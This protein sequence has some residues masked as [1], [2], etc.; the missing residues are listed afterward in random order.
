MKSFFALGRRVVVAYLKYKSI[1]Q[2]REIN[3]REAVVS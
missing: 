1:S 3:T 2:H